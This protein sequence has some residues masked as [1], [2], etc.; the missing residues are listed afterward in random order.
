MH[1][2]I[3]YV[4]V[5]LATLRHLVHAAPI[6]DGTHNINANNAGTGAG[7]NAGGGSVNS[8]PIKGEEGLL[9][10]LGVGSL[11][12]VNSG[13]CP[14]R[15]IMYA[16]IHSRNFA[17]GNAGHG[18]KANSGSAS[19]RPFRRYGTEKHYEETTNT[20]ETKGNANTGAG[21]QAPGGSVNG[22]HGLI[23]IDSCTS[24]SDPLLRV[25]TCLQRQSTPETGER[26]TAGTP[27]LI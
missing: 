22:P 6:P 18:G 2:S 12:N 9:G 4:L 11:L 3:P 24:L 23:N 5:I 19:S 17:V 14:F 15:L 26:L 10:L 27:L 1:F 21:G 8:S 7:G 20:N 13:N 16:R 25:L